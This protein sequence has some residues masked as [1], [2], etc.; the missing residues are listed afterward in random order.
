MLRLYTFGGLRIERDG[1]PLQL[2]TQKARELL[3][4]L[5]AFR[6]RPHSRSVLAGTLWPDLPEDQA[7]LCRLLTEATAQEAA[8]TIKH[9]AEALGVSPATLNTNLSTLR[10]QGW[11]TFTKGYGTLNTCRVLRVTCFPQN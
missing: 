5:I 7:C 4:Y 2:P 9:L 10:R 6:E 3:A 1:Q 8:P 11:P